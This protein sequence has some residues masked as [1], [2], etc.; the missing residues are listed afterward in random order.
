MNPPPALVAIFAERIAA[1]L[2]AARRHLAAVPERGAL[3]LTI[4]LDPA[5]PSWNVPGGAPWE[6]PGPAPLRTW[7]QGSG[8]ATSWNEGAI[9]AEHAERLR[10]RMPP[11]LTAWY[12]G[13]RLSGLDYAA[14]LD[15]AEELAPAHVAQLAAEL[16]GALDLVAEELRAAPELDAAGLAKRWPLE[17]DGYEDG[18]KAASVALLLAELEGGKSW[19]LRALMMYPHGAPTVSEAEISAL[20]GWL[21]EVRS[22]HPD[23]PWSRGLAGRTI[24][25]A[26]LLR[27][28]EHAARRRLSPLFAAVEARRAVQ[29]LVSDEGSRV[30]LAAVD[31][32]LTPRETDALSDL[33]RADVARRGA[34][35]GALVAAARAVALAVFQ[36]P[37]PV[38]DNAAR[39]TTGTPPAL[40]WDRRFAAELNRLG[41]ARTPDVL[42]L[43]VERA[44]TSGADLWH[45]WAPVDGP[46][47]WLRALARELWLSLWRPALERE[48]RPVA[49]S[50]FA[51][52]R[53]GGVLLGRDVT[54]G[55]GGRDVLVDGAG[56][57]VA[58]FELPRLATLVDAD[59]LERLARPGVGALTTIAAARFVPWF[60]EQVQR[61]PVES[62]ALVFEG[63]DGVNAWGSVAVA[64]GMDPKNSAEVC[65]MIHA[66]QA[67]IIQYPNGDEAGVLMFDYR[68]GGGRGNPS[69]LT[70]RPG[71][72]WL[73][74][75]VHELPDGAEY[76]AL[77][78][79]PALE[80]Y[81]PPFVGDRRER[82]ALARLWLCLLIELTREAPDLSLGLGA[83]IPTTRWAELAQTVGVIRPP[84]LL[85]SLLQN[86]WAADGD[87]GRAVLERVGPDR[88]HLAPRFEAERAMLEAGGRMRRGAAEGGR[89]AAKGRAEE[90]GRLA[91]GL[92]RK[93]KGR[94]GS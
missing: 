10:L 76:R 16:T 17:G 20:S 14:A 72:P 19:D 6:G 8:F 25:A 88:W 58:R 31:A 12:A 45:L 53:I 9:E 85:V 64:L 4:P 51:V 13:D 7:R 42:A 28:A 62:D 82:A 86:R 52:E 49:L 56:R 36:D 74:T 81:A 91:D 80:G 78:P 40:L 24:D 60:A 3:L 59:A 89:R 5:P 65:R 2:L 1:A 73:S 46:P 41:G 57:A 67:T 90:R 75:D 66:L 38:D 33:A 87:D 48:R 68:Q 27:R 77:A 32:A 93:P 43:A 70:I 44:R 54:P 18:N 15:L 94:K 30:W 84:P 37:P 63:A 83:H 21:A 22:T 34:Y 55:P 39:E 47:L 23:H 11:R 92:P 35:A 79:I 71:R 69:R 26:A 50:R 29:D 61:R